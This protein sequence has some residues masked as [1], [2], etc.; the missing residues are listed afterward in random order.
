MKLSLEVETVHA[1]HELHQAKFLKPFISAN[2][3]RGMKLQVKLK[4]KL[5]N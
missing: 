3:E 5:L 1:M 2:I 4:L